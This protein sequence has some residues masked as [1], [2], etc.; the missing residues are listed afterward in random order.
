MKIQE[1]EILFEL[2]GVNFYPHNEIKTKHQ[3]SS[4]IHTREYKFHATAVKLK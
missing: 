1:I 2:D 3:I 4:P